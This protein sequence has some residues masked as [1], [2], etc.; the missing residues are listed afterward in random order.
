MT[1]FSQRDLTVEGRLTRLEILVYVLM[2]MSGANVIGF[3]VF[4]AIHIFP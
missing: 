3:R 1:R 2:V 4:D